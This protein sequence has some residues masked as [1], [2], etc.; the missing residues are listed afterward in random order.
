MLNFTK[1]FIFFFKKPSVVLI[2][3]KWRFST[4]DAIFQVLK[5][6][7]KIRKISENILPLARN[8]SEILIFMPDLANSQ[9]LGNFNF[10]LKRSR[11][12]ILVVTAAVENQ[13]GK[14]AEFLPSHGFIIV[15][16]DSGLVRKI[17]NET[18]AHVLTYGSEE[19]ADFRVTDINLGEEETNFKTNYEGD[20]VPF[21]FKGLLGK[22]EIYNI[23]AAISVGVVNNLNLVEI[24]Q[25]LKNFELLSD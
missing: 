12:P 17:K 22:E 2:V 25:I 19:G 14:L 18:Q 7:F 21:W 8:K 24:S 16:S 23:L 5:S 4:E 6:N 13:I 15:N 1:K 20:I 9:D 10:L 3:G 11:L